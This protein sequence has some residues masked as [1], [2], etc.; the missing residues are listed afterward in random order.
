MSM[1][2]MDTLQVYYR[3]VSFKI[4][5]QAAQRYQVSWQGCAQDRIS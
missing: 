2:T 3:Q 5:T 4:P 1:R